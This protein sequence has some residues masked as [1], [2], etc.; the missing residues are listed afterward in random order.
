[1][2]SLFPDPGAP[3]LDRDFETGAWRRRD[4]PMA[5]GHHRF[6]RWPNES[7]FSLEARNFVDVLRRHVAIPNAVWEP[8]AGA[9][10]LARELIESGLRVLATDLHEYDPVQGAPYIGVGYN[11]LE[12]TSLPHGVR[13][14]VMNPPFDTAE[15]HCERAIS[16]LAQADGGVVACLNRS[17]WGT[18][19]RRAVLVHDHPAFDLKIE[20]VKRPIWR[21]KTG[22]PRIDQ[23]PRHYFAWFVWRLERGLNDPKRIAWG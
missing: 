22:D 12:Q 10:H 3:S 18:G 20:I 9:G 11:F 1:M 2:R 8:H 16:L 15:E 7:Y 14:I 19:K 17:E 23:S 5:T 6:E 4:R 21:E 13:A